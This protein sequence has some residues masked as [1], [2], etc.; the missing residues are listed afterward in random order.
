ME[1]LFPELGGPAFA[2]FL[3]RLNLLGSCPPQVLLIEGGTGEE[4]YAAARWW[5]CRCNCPCVNAD[6]PC[7]ACDV[8]R[9]IHAQEYMD[10]PAFD[11]C[12]SN[13]QDEDAPGLVRALSMEN[14]RALKSRLKDPPHGD[15]LRV[16]LL[17]GLER[18]RTSAANALLKV[19]EEPSDTN[20]FVLLAAQRA[21]LLPTLVSRAH[22][23]VLP[24]PDPEGGSPAEKSLVADLREFLRGGRG[25]F[26][27]T[28]TKSFGRNEAA[29]ILDLVQKAVMRC[30]SG[31]SS[32]EGLDPELAG[33]DTA[34][35][36]SVSRWIL[37][38]RQMLRD[39]TA[40]GRVVEAFMCR[41]YVLLLQERQRPAGRR[42]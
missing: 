28:G 29:C 39:Q 17:M 31:R 15:G 22:C 41:L 5:A 40:P 36:A 33:L 2:S 16:V 42:K 13:T 19:L 3:R 30:L 8:C 18:Q 11:G 35:L 25:L 24:W 1:A 10:V 32:S 38:A 12:I 9:Q 7:L 6:G 34:A 21:Q 23:L 20:L 37:E 4:R 26:P 27:R 14:V